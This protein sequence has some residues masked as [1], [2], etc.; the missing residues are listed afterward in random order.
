MNAEDLIFPTSLKTYREEIAQIKNA[1]H[2]EFEAWHKRKNGTFVQ[3]K[4]YCSSISVNRREMVI[5]TH[6][7]LTDIHASQHALKESEERFRSFFDNA[8]DCVFIT[9]SNGYFLNINDLGKALLGIETNPA[10][11]DLFSLFINPDECER[12]RK[13][14]ASFGFVRDFRTELHRIGG[15]QISVEINASFFHNPIYHLTGYN[16][17]IR[18]VTNE[19]SMGAQLLQAQKLDAIGRLA[20]GIA[21]D[22]NNVL[23][24]IIGNTELSLLSIEADHELYE[25]LCQIKESAERAARLTG[26]LLAFGR[27]Q[28]S[29]TDIINPYTIIND[30]HRML[31]R[32][33]GDAIDLELRLDPSANSIN[34]DQNQFEQ[35]ILNLVLNAH[36]AIL[37]KTEGKERKI[38]IETSYI[39]IDASFVQSHEGI[40]QGAY[41]L[42]SVIDTGAGIPEENLDK[43]FDPF[44][45][46]KLPNKGS[47]LGLSTVF[48][49]ITQ[50]KASIYV[51][52]IP[53][54]NTHFDI[55][56]PYSGETV[57]SECD[58]AIEE[59]AADESILVIEDEQ[60]LC[61]FTST[62]LRKKGY[63]V[64]SAFNAE[65][66]RVIVAAHSEIAL[67]FIDI[68]IPGKNG[69]QLAQDI[70]YSIPAIK[71]I[72][73]SGFPDSYAQ[74]EETFSEKAD[75]LKKPYTIASLIQMIRKNLKV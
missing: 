21:H 65:D 56:W 69:V 41:V 2:S 10:E 71:I 40:T 50:N 48:G 4:T 13:G 23:T 3:I 12:F 55:Y 67:A 70:K 6:H 19:I 1:K 30:F 62:A 49:I 59:C 33:I 8:K 18:D 38:I 22:F 5:E 29:Q 16:G 58:D 11:I 34:A 37:E 26:Q 47:G 20:G 72:F 9:T 75:F 60:S 28:I 31:K 66:A 24:V 52:S 17:F 39:Y 42:I 61:N 51:S 14:I 74:Y 36:D 32:I 27:K 44:F 15:S 45:T 53:G 7:D 57:E 35:V 54:Q 68:V 64:Y 73:T 46:T 25:P 63:L 43:I